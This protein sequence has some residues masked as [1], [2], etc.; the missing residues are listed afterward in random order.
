MVTQEQA[1]TENTFH[2]TGPGGSV[3]HPRDN[4]CRVDTGPRGGQTFHVVRCRRNGSTQTWKTRPGD[5]RLPIKAGMREY[6]SISQDN[7]EHFHVAHECPVPE[8]RY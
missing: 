3:Y 5:F 4:S 7:A 6:G 2:Y 8:L 1:L